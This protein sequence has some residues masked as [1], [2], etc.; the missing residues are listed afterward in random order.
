MQQQPTTSHGPSDTF[1]HMGLIGEAPLNADKSSQ[2]AYS[3]LL[4]PAAQFVPSMRIFPKPAEVRPR[5]N[6]IREVNRAYIHHFNLS[7]NFVPNIVA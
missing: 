3:C 2:A 5:T 4:Q 7:K 6:E 1:G